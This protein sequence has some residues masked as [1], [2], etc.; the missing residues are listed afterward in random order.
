MKQ[1]MIYSLPA[2]VMLLLFIMPSLL[3]KKKPFF[4]ETI[5]RVSSLQNAAHVSNFDK[6]LF[7][8]FLPPQS[9]SVR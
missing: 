1:T 2:G 6:F 5:K 9:V 4:M 8:V 3:K 7:R